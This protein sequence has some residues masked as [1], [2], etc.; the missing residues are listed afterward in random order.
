MS[1]FPFPLLFPCKLFP[2]RSAMA[3]IREVIITSLS[4]PFSEVLIPV[5]PQERFKRDLDPLSTDA[6]W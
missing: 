1:P 2:L 4:A 3:M 5:F 6:P